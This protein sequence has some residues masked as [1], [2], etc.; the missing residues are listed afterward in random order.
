[1]QY[2]S[3][4]FLDSRVN[5]DIIN[6][7]DI[8]TLVAPTTKEGIKSLLKELRDPVLQTSSSN[9]TREVDLRSKN[10]MFQSSE[11]ESS[12]R[13]KAFRGE[14]ECILR[15]IILNVEGV[16]LVDRI[17]ASSGPH[18]TSPILAK[19]WRDVLLTGL[20]PHVYVKCQG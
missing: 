12:R 3:M 9:S 13:D 8:V 10:E 19:D 4:Q 15:R 11:T 20:Q 18:G 6:G 16:G 14:T 5:F 17:I 1:M 2:F 7:L